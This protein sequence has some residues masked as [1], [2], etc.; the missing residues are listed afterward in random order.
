MTKEPRNRRPPADEWEAPAPAAKRKGVSRH[1]VLL[2]AAGGVLRS[3]WVAGR[4]V[5][6]REDVDRWDPRAVPSA[7]QEPAA[8]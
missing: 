4:L 8:A 5:V 1:A 3:Q 7:Q 6:R 2:A